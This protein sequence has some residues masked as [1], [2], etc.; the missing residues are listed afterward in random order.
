M[1]VATTA[2]EVLR[3]L[4]TSHEHLAQK[5][6]EEMLKYYMEN[7]TSIGYERQWR[8]KVLR[9]TMRGYMKILKKVKEGIQG[10]T[11]WKRTHCCQ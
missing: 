4:K 10:E 7:L 9:S 8:I 2:Q 5:E 3:R 11:E 6:V 1:K